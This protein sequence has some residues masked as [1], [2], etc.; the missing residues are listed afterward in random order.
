MSR[1]LHKLVRQARQKKITLQHRLNLH[2]LPLRQVKIIVNV[3]SRD[4]LS[5]RIG[6]L[7]GFLF[8]DFDEVAEL[9][10]VAVCIAFAQLGGYDGGSEVADYPGGG[11]LNGVYEGGGEEE[12]AELF[13]AVGGIEEG[14]EGPV[15]EPGSV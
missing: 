7:I 13:A 10:L 14:E 1:T 8:D 5:D 2:Q 9:F 15:D 6:V 3:Q 11:S 4:K 12:F